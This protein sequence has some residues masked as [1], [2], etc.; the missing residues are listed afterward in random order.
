M[1]CLGHSTIS[2]EAWTVDVST[3]LSFCAQEAIEEINNILA[4]VEKRT[5]YIG[6]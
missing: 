1:S 5:L 2:I 3:L 6:L 4:G